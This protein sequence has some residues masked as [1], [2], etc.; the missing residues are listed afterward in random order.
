MLGLPPMTREEKIMANVMESCLFKSTLA[1]VLGAGLGVAFGL[2][3]ASVD[4]S[5]SISKDPTKPVKYFF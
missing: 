4:P 3:T 2:F 1:C 5:L